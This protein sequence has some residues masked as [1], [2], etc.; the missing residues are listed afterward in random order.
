MGEGVES[1]TKFEK[2]GEGVD[3][4]GG[5][6]QALKSDASPQVSLILGL[7]KTIPRESFQIRFEVFIRLS[8]SNDNFH[9]NLFLNNGNTLIFHFF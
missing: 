6:P 3:S 4:I 2:A 9:N 7:T 1:W 8:S 5:S